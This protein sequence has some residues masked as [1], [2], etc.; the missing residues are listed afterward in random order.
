MRHL[1][2]EKLV[3]TRSR[4]VLSCTTYAGQVSQNRL[5]LLPATF[6]KRPVDRY[7]RSTEPSTRNPNRK[8]DSV[9]LLALGIVKAARFLNKGAA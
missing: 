2:G 6:E 9:P 4:A 3:K 8:A 5:V 7:E 1:F